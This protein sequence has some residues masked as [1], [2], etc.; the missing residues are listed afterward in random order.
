MSKACLPTLLILLLLGSAAAPAQESGQ[1]CIL[2]YD[3]QNGNGSKEAEEPALREGVAA[4]MLNERGVTIK[5][6]LLADSPLAERGIFCLDDVPAGEFVLRLTSAQHQPTTATS[7]TASV[8]PGAAPELIFFGANPVRASTDADSAMLAGL[9][10]DQLASLG[11]IAVALLM[12]V[13]L[14]IALLLLALLIFLGVIR[15]RRRRSR[16]R[17]LSPRRSVAQQTPAP[18]SPAPNRIDEDDTPPLL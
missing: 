4:H 10:A 1:I 13:A 15:P 3:D 12:I 5:S 18:A 16:S 2:A 14:A 17:S 8:S 7:V 11:E 6:V 9:S